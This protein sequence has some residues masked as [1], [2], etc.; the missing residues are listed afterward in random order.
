MSWSVFS[1]YNIFVMQIANRDKP[2][3]GKK[4]CVFCCFK[5]G[6]STTNLHLALDMYTDQINR[7]QSSTILGGMQHLKYTIHVYTIKSLTS[8]FHAGGNVSGSSFS[9]TTNF[10]VGYLVSLGPLVS[11]TVQP[12]Q[13]LHTISEKSIIQILNLYRSTLLSVVHHYITRNENSPCCE[14][15]TCRSNH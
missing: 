6:D 8:L 14:R 7:L 12:T 2:N 5:A 11:T 1:T 3:S 10:C 4:T 13:V 15:N 9:E